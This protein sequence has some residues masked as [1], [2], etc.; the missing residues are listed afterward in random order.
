MTLKFTRDWTYLLNND[1]VEN[2]KLQNHTKPQP[3]NEKTLSTKRRAYERNQLCCLMLS[4]LTPIP[5]DSGGT[6]FV[7]HHLNPHISGKY[8]PGVSQ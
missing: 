8:T 7:P 5:V 4:L 1:K 3:V 6:F 2:P